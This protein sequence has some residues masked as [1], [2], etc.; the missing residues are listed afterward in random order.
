MLAY[1]RLIQ[2]EKSSFKQSRRSTSAGT[3]VRFRKSIT[4]AR[5]RTTVLLACMNKWSKLL[6]GA[7]VAIVHGRTNTSASEYPLIHFENNF[8]IG[9]NRHLQ[10]RRSCCVL[11][12]VQREDCP[13][14][15]SRA[16]LRPSML[17]QMDRRSTAA[18]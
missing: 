7:S 14:S 18:V 6:R 12:A 2:K 8:N 16:P 9:L 13:S 10:A 3:N 4:G 11:Q 1:L 17:L 5:R 15:P